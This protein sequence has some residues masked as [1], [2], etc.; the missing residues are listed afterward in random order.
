MIYQN[1]QLLY[2][3]FA[4]AIPILIH[5]FNLRKHKTVY[6]SSI[7]FLKEVKEENKK[8]SQLR[9][10]LILISRILAISFLVIAFAKPYIPAENTTNTKNI[11]LYIDNSQSMDIDF[12]K[13]NLLNNAKNTARE[14]ID[15]YPSENNFYLITNDFLSKHTSSYTNK[16]IKIQI[17]KITPSPKEKS[18]TEIISRQESIFSRNSH[19]Y[20]I[21]DFQENTLKID[22]LKSSKINNKNGNN[23]LAIFIKFL[24]NKLYNYEN[25]NN[26]NKRKI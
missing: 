6:F 19:L 26:I 24:F 1:P 23:N 15:T 4:I 11:F 16:A 5:L 8:K 3:L 14:I 10:I 12:G 2:A 20:F 25:F 13:G 9:N 18:I 21:S 22:G 7:R 17:E